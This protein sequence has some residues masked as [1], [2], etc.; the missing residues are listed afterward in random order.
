MKYLLERVVLLNGGGELNDEMLA[1]APGTARPVNTPDADMDG[2]T[3]DSAEQMLIKQALERNH[4]NVSKA[5][6]E[7]GVTRMVLR[8]RMKKYSLQ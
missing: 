1:L 4:G 7:L 6:R 3:L 5:A 8:Y 2:M